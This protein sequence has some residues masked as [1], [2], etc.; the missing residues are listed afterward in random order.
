[1][2]KKNEKLK[3]RKVRAILRYH[4]PNQNKRPEEY[5]HHL[6]FMYYPFRKEE[7]LH[8]ETYMENLV[9]PEVMRVVNNNKIKIEPFG[10]LV[11]TALR[12]LRSNLK[13]NQDSHAQQENDE[14]ESLFHNAYTLLSEDAGGDAVLFDYNANA[15]ASFPALPI[16]LP[17]DEIN[18]MICSLNLNQRKIF[19]VIMRWARNHIKYLSFLQKRAIDPIHLFITGDGGCGKSH[20][21]KTVFNALSKSRSYHAGNP[22]K[23]KV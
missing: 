3:Y 18:S 11:E 10:N 4:V 9:N 5:A 12:S 20:L 15:T 16:L 23:P 21:A 2:S 13:N 1:M 22:E 17:D 14:V 7:D 8:K 19:D 6:L